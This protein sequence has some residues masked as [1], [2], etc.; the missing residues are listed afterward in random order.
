[1]T[2]AQ[3]FLYHVGCDLLIGVTIAFL[4]VLFH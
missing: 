2:F 3:F 1:M 4:R